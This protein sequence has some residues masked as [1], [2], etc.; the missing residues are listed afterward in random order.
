[1]SLAW[2]GLGEVL[3]P[4]TLL[5]PLPASALCPVPSAQCPELSVH[6]GPCGKLPFQSGCFHLARCTGDSLT[7]LVARARGA[8]LFTDK[9]YPIV[10]MYW[11]FVPPLDIGLFLVFSCY[12]EAAVSRFV[13]TWLFAS[14]LEWEYGLSVGDFPD[15]GFT[16]SRLG[17][18]WQSLY[19]RLLWNQSWVRSLSPR[20][21]IDE[22]QWQWGRFRSE[23]SILDLLWACVQHMQAPFIPPYRW[24]DW[25]L[26]V[27]F[28][29]LTYWVQEVGWEPGQPES[30]S[31]VCWTSSLPPSLSQSWN[32][33]Q[34]S[35]QRLVLLPVES[36]PY[37]TITI[38]WC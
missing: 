10:G 24:W 18:L 7:H 33:A 14:S 25:G 3:F 1:M 15:E 13:W 27:K 11:L 5:L 37:Q 30:L 20:V 2:L 34:W 32:A 9:Y 28:L 29:R 23:F 12:N 6:S 17:L 19:C 16:A 36:S 8:A 22:G 38:T 35:G 21:H 31:S 4:E 26:E